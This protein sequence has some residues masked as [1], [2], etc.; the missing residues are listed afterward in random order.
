MP[1][2]G[3]PRAV[4][5][6]ALRRPIKPTARKA[7][8]RRKRFA[9]IG[10]VMAVGSEKSFTLT[11]A[12]RPGP[13]KRGRFME[14]PSP[15][16]EALGI[17]EQNEGSVSFAVGSVQ[18]KAEALPPA[19]P[20]LIKSG[21]RQEALPFWPRPF[22]NSQALRPGL[23]KSQPKS[24]RFA[25]EA[26]TSRKRFT[27]GAVF[28][29]SGFSERSASGGAARP[30]GEALRSGRRPASKRFSRGKHC[31]GPKKRDTPGGVSAVL[32]RRRSSGRW[33][34]RRPPGRRSVA[35]GWRWPGS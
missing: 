4:N 1:P 29:L 24:K 33:V 17:A 6:E 27:P 26:C 34:W 23:D 31:P 11:E 3:W 10:P 7:L 18:A 13:T 9:G 2:P 15:Q 16:S 20:A 30:S 32:P 25:L 8:A 28:S 21:G 5:G 12:L 19:G 14:N 22:A 35:A